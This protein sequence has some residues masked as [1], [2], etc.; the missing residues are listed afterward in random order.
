VSKIVI[1]ATTADDW[2]RLL[3]EPEKQWRSGYSAKALAQC[4]Q[5]AD[6][7][8]PSVRAVLEEAPDP[9]LHGLTMLLGIPEHRV[10][11]PGGRRA[12][13]TDLFVLAKATN[14]DLISITV[15]GKVAEPFGPLVSEWLTAEAAG[16]SAGRV[17]RLR[18][19]VDRLGLTEADCQ[20]LRYQ[21]LHRTAS[22][23]IEA[24]RFNARHAMLLVHSFSGAYAWFSD[25]AEF[26]RLLGAEVEPSAIARGAVPGDV[27]L[28]LAW[29]R[30]EARYLAV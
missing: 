17:E 26:A 27:G 4:W 20:P 24:G 12:S 23:L 19:L 16:P 1:P 8:P 28:Y 21:L 13:Q 7:F 5:A 2:R 18:F 30:G 6:D 25:Y 15:E 10:P 29:V 9:V 3:A 22:A 14:G 11:L